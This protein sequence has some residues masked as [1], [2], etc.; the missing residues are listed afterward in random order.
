ME[1][2]EL[3]DV[4]FAE[5]VEIKDA[6]DRILTTL[7]KQPEKSGELLA[8]AFR[9][10][11]TLKGN[12]TAVG[13]TP[14]ANLVHVVEDILASL[15]KNP[16]VLSTDI[17]NELL[18]ANDKIGDV[19]IAWKAE[20]PLITRG[21]LTRLEVLQ[22]NIALAYPTTP[23]N[24]EVNAFMPIEQT[25]T[26]IQVS[27]TISV[28]TRKLDYLLDLV[29]EL[30]IE[31]DR[32]AGGVLNKELTRL[33]RLTN[34][35]HHAVLHTRLVQVQDLWQK[36][37]RLVRDT[38][39]AEKKQVELV[40]EGND[41]E[42]DRKILPI[43]TE[44]LVH[45]IRNAISHGIELPQDRQHASKPAAGKLVL[46]ASG[47]RDRVQ[48][49]ITDDGRGISPAY[50]R[51][52]V[53]RKG[54]MTVESAS[55][56][57]DEQ[58]L[59]CVFLAGFSS[60]ESVSEI[61]GRGIGLDVVK[62]SVEAIGGC[63]SLTT[64]VGK[65]S[66]FSLEL[67]SSI[68]LKPVLLFEAVRITWA[69]PI[70]Y[71]VDIVAYQRADLQQI[72][73]S[74]WVK[75][76][77][78]ALPILFPA[79]ILQQGT[80]KV[81]VENH[82][83]NTPFLVIR[84]RERGQEVG[85]LADKLLQQKEIFEKPLAPPLHTLRLVSGASILGNGRIA[86]TLD[87]RQWLSFFFETKKNPHKNT[88]NIPQDKLFDKITKNALKASAEAFSVWLNEPIEVVEAITEMCHIP[89][90]A[91]IFVTE[92]QGDWQASSWLIC[93][94]AQMQQI[95]NLM[96]NK[97]MPIAL[98]SELDNILC[99]H[100]ITYMDHARQML[101]FGGVPQTFVWHK[102]QPLPA[103]QHVI[104]CTL[105]STKSDLSLLFSWFFV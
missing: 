5:A 53:V 96:Q 90:N 12:A 14:L 20:K 21:M 86:L 34:E 16:H 62:K 46:R 78:L 84:L 2:G 71:V 97:E 58:A 30:S 44:S 7:E 88:Q 39:Q 4:F 1:N 57:T 9:H 32:L 49:D 101:A 59:Q 22:R 63:V 99:A 82:P 25:N 104:S 66:T 68:A 75:K 60:V 26:L 19:L 43:L 51:E 50:L 98:L 83:P 45:L 79:Q 95:A 64:E 89:E 15:Q 91:H 29:G 92:V 8:E 31:N 102:N 23:N 3:R 54:L 38:A 11:H 77:N 52:A 85:I 48:I 37:Y 69:I 41:S 61:S 35:L 100:F 80:A 72:G 28:A 17:T 13:I 74:Y 87:I 55:K 81:F 70:D 94:D 10:L 93:T 42:I 6:L 47:Y 103:H 73:N 67:P 105:K 27:E 33:T 65:G 18:R 36:F 24:E 56:M 40:L 76:G